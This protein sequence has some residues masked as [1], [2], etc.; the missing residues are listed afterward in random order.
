[1]TIDHPTPV[2]I[3]ALKALW[4]TVFGD[5]DEYIQ[6]FFSTAFSADRCLCV[7]IDKKPVCV[8]YW[9]DT[10][11]QDQRLAY[12]YAVATDPAHRK[13]GL[14]RKLIAHTHR[15]LQ[16]LCYAGAI[17][18]PAE[19]SLFHMYEK[20]GYK[21]C[22]YNHAFSCAAS[23]TPAVLTE[24]SGA[25]YAT[26]RQ[27][28]LPSGSVGQSGV[29]WRFLE[30]TMAF[31]QYEGAVFACYRDDGSAYVRELLGTVSCPGDLVAGLGCRRGFFRT[32]GSDTPFAM[33]NLWG[34]AASAAPK[35]LG[36]SLD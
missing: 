18:M 17:L 19:D 26:M 15:H 34:D 30:K 16:T 8:L 25:Q 20:M 12:L 33:A 2:Q 9:F 23:D 14:C 1:M 3:P 5:P 36:F 21:T 28:L 4:K 31:Y 27:A 24:L 29:M 10:Q 6:L 13:K 32:P 22:C 7:T 35:Y 11:Y